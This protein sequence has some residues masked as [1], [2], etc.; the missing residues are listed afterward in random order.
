LKALQYYPEIDKLIKKY[1]H[2]SPSSSICKSS[3]SLS[4]LVF[5]YPG[6]KKTYQRSDYA[7]LSD[8][9]DGK[10]RTFIVG[11]YDQQVHVSC[12]DAYNAA[13]TIM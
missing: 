7:F 6:F 3:A 9:S 13:I 10:T 2:L 5:H 8:T 1:S 4:P 11:F 12:Y